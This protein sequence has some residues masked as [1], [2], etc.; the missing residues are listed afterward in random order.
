MHG[1]EIRLA[2]EWCGPKWF[3]KPK[4]ERLEFLG[5]RRVSLGK[6]S[7]LKYKPICYTGSTPLVKG[8]PRPNTVT[9]FR[10]MVKS[11]AAEYA[12]DDTEE[13]PTT[14]ILNANVENGSGFTAQCTPARQEV[15]AAE[16]VLVTNAGLISKMFHEDVKEPVARGTTSKWTQMAMF[17]QDTEIED[18]RLEEFC[19][20]P[21][22]SPRQQPRCRWTQ[23]ALTLMDK[24]NSLS[25]TEEDVPEDVLEKRGSF[26]SSPA[27]TPPTSFFKT[28]FGLDFEIPSLYKLI[29]PPIIPSSMV[30]KDTLKYGALPVVLGRGS[31]GRVIRAKLSD[32][33]GDTQNIVVKEIFDCKSQVDAIFEEARMLLFLSRTGYVP[34]CF[35]VVSDGG[36]G[37]AYGILMECVGDGLTL[38]RYLWDRKGRLAPICLLH[39]AR[40]LAEGLREIHNL[41]V[42]LNDIKANNVLLDITSGIPKVKYCDFGQARYGHGVKI[43]G[44]VTDNRYLYLAPEV[45]N[46]G[47]S[48]LKSDIH[49]VGFLFMVLSD[50]EGSDA[51]VPAVKRCMVEDISLR[52]NAE[53]LAFM[54][55]KIF[56]DHLEI[57]VLSDGRIQTNLEMSVFD[58]GNGAAECSGNK[59]GCDLENVLPTS[60]LCRSRTPSPRDS[61]N[62]PANPKVDIHVS[63][64]S[65]ATSPCMDIYAASK[66]V[67]EKHPNHSS[68]STS[69]EDSYTPSEH[70]VPISTCRLQRCSSPCP[71]TQYDA[72][73]E[74]SG[75]ES[76]SW[77]ITSKRSTHLHAELSGDGYHSVTTAYR[78]RC[79]ISPCHVSSVTLE[80]D[81]NSSSS[82]VM[83]TTSYRS[84]SSASLSVFEDC[85]EVEVFHDPPQFENFE[86]MSVILLF[87]VFMVMLKLFLLVCL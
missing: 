74:L 55:D 60:M 25:L 30:K 19:Q 86:S 59:M 1:E 35:G 40:Q 29:N 69:N 37:E 11:A 67:Y 2:P 77:V 75:D 23:L 38:E 34:S 83:S 33:Q 47:V 72:D 28:L 48:C 53:D 3:H 8:R 31:F 49:S 41:G 12:R 51:L 71:S 18:H 66:S 62:P 14:S 85:H 65:N 43:S 46:G 21:Q 44:R 7:A 50:F 61:V 63:S 57:F 78:G 45:R 6:S 54:V 13:T 70:G 82:E 17:L 56:N 10:E 16:R 5:L 39:I 80:P 87:I 4:E 84:N 76:Q 27:D 68:S 36:V 52:I 26:D 15:V 22:P 32:S 9:R 64:E 24:D 81:V 79:S 42:L 73:D 20:T 58:K